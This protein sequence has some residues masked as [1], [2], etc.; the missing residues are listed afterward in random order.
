MKYV[1]FG[2]LAPDTIIPVPFPKGAT[3]MD[4]VTESLLAKFATEHEL[5][6]LPDD[7]RF[8]HFAGY[9][10]VR[11][12][13]R[14]TFL[15]TDI[16]TGG[17]ND[18]GID[19]IAI[20]VNG[21]LV[22]DVDELDDIAP[23]GN[24]DVVFIFVQADRGPGFDGA[25]IGNSGYGVVDFFA[26]NHSLPRNDYIK[27]AALITS[28][29]IDERAD[30]FRRKRPQCHLYFVT[31]GVWQ[32]DALLEAR[33]QSV[34]E[35]LSRLN[36]FSE[37]TFTPAGANEIQRYYTDT[38]NTISK[39][40]DFPR[41]TTAP[42]IRGVHQAFLGFVTANDYLSVITDEHG[43]MIRSIFYDNVRDWQGENPVNA[44]MTKTLHN[45]DTKDRFLLM[46]N[47]VTIIAR[48]LNNLA[49]VS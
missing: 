19:A 26:S 39:R 48:S 18:T 49:I 34:V 42:E 9:I 41:K 23:A 40:F 3:L 12:Q 17:G 46:K 14:E 7:R 35:D 1:P 20:L 6:G 28:A 43:E 33:R 8:E 36:I 30:R 21:Q 45:D 31:S 32:N 16:A 13:H 47:G 38:K 24:L 15:T 27:D 37:V 25:K 4:R 44:G 5:T 22:T 11:Q 10:T 29:L 2:R